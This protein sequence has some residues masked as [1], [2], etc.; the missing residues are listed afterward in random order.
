MK[1]LSV[2]LAIVASSFL[3]LPAF[4][5]DQPYIDHLS[6]DEEIFANKLN[7]DNRQAFMQ[8]PEDK[9]RE[10]IDMTQAFDETGSML[11]PDAAVD[12]VR[13]MMEE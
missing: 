12:K 4:S 10:C 2:F 9:K 7:D 6:V 1:K 5:E 13:S 8:M 3:G 11:S